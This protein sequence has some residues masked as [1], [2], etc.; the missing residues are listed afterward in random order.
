M[1]IISALSQSH[2]SKQKPK[3]HKG[4]NKGMTKWDKKN[5]KKYINFF[6]KKTKRR[7]GYFSI[8]FR[9]HP[10][11]LLNIKCV[12]QAA[13]IPSVPRCACSDMHRPISPAATDLLLLASSP[14]LTQQKNKNTPHIISTSYLGFHLTHSSANH[15]LNNKLDLYNRSVS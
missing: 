9:F 12:L 8:W 10:L 4:T 15:Q 3:G 11:L 14:T 1:A 6:L 13:C 2:Q 7:N 5:K